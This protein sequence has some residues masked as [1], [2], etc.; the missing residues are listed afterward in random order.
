MPILEINN[1]NVKCTHGSTIADLDKNQIFYLQSRGISL[2]TSYKMLV[3][4]FIR[5]VIDSFPDFS[6]K[7]LL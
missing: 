6:K 3:N 2:E 1:D 4:S 5:D 7:I